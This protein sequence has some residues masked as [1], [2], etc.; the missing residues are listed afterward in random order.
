MPSVLNSREIEKI[1]FD[2]TKKPIYEIADFLQENLGQKITAY[3]SG[4][5]HPKEVGNWISKHA[6]PQDT[7]TMRLRYAYQAARMLIDI[8]D[9]N[10]AKAWFFGSNTRLDD[11]APAFLIRNANDP[12]SLRFIIPA[13][14]AFAETA[15]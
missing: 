5:K 14:R 7:K 12:E 8:Y 4:L 3:I 2:A 1:Q 9:A 11:E 6:N 15:E 13:A 10:T